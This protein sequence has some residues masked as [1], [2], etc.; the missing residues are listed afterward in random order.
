EVKSYYDIYRIREE[1]H[2]TCYQHPV[3]NA[4]GL[5][6]TEALMSASGCLLFRNSLGKY[7]SL[8]DAVDDMGVYIQLDDNILTLI[9]HLD[10]E[11][12][13]HAKEILDKVER[14][15]I[16]SYIGNF[17]ISSKIFPNKIFRT[18]AVELTCG[19]QGQDPLQNVFCYTKENL[20]K[21]T[22]VSR[23]QVSTLLP[24]KFH[25]HDVR[26]Y[27]KN[28]DRKLCSVIR[29]AF[30][31]WC[32]KKGYTVPKETVE[33]KP[34]ISQEKG[35]IPTSSATIKVQ[36]KAPPPLPVPLPVASTSTSNDNNQQNVQ[37]SQVLRETSQNSK[38]YKQDSVNSDG[39]EELIVVQTET[40]WI[41]LSKKFI[42][43]NRN[44]NVQYAHIYAER[45]LVMLP[46]VKKAAE[47]RWG[48]A[49]AIKN[50]A[51]IQV[52]EEC[53]I[54]GTLFKQ[55]ILKPSI[56]KEL[57]ADNGF[58]PQP[59]RTRYVD[60][61]DKLILEE[62]SQR[63]TLS[64]NIDTN[65]LVTGVV[66]AARGHEDE[67]GTFIVSDYCFKDL[68]PQDVLLLPKE[69]KFV[70]F[71]S[72]FQL[73]ENS[74]IF[75]QMQTF[76]QSFSPS[77]L[78][79]N[80]DK[81]VQKILSNTIRVLVVGNLVDN[82]TRSKE[83]TNQPK[84]ITRKLA[85]SSIEAMRSV[86]ELLE[87]IAINVDLD[88]VPGLNDPSCHMLPQQ[89]LHPSMFP[90]LSLKKTT[91]CV[92]NPYEFQIGHIRFLGTSGQNVD[93]IAVQSSIDS[94]LQILENCLSWG[95]IAPTCPDTL[96]CYPYV[97]NDPF[98]ILNTPNIFFAGN[99]PKFEQRMFEDGKT[100]IQLICIP[101]FAN[102][103]TCVALNLRT[104]ECVEISFENETPSLVT[105]PTDDSNMDIAS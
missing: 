96:S 77:K 37:S 13:N 42:L 99:Q 31:H 41:N 9:K 23:D 46:L 74:I 35:Q 7:I 91:H 21:A 100:K 72:G 43:K 10:D 49:V 17:Q 25:E 97:D 73:S 63:I 88:I 1:L 26:L 86:D 90:S 58:V 84:Y 8:S 32:A 105:V 85:P 14:R 95:V 69:E 33:T 64:G 16:Y 89:P 59:A 82:S 51:D 67:K 27:C 44:F 56:V 45:L 5:M 3:V 22:K 87:Q 57:S 39:K 48:K 102:S 15:G 11:Q 30:K 29:Y 55:M 19:N 4:I 78:S 50:M 38:R 66:M 47:N 18:K 6:L 61:S 62:V 65:M 54:I 52:D 81:Q 40:E 101:A 80:C 92:T 104:M 70:I 24:D 71:V 94:R 36:D 103:L 12:L 93:D 76:V 53:I 79:S 28:R 20:N 98:V 34:V 2:R 83:F 75:D 68:P 60:P